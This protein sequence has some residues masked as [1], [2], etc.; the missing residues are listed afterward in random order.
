MMSLGFGTVAR[1]IFPTGSRES[2]MTAFRPLSIII[3]P[4]L[5][6][7]G[8]LLFST[9]PDFA[10]VIR[11]ITPLG[12]D[13]GLSPLS[14]SGFILCEQIEW[15]ALTTGMPLALVLIPVL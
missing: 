4:G 3:S 13:Y 14:V 11:T 15:S 8:S 9:A 5:G 2:A 6:M 1:A 10:Y 7:M 12:A